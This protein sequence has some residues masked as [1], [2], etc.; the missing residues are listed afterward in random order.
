MCMCI[1]LI[2]KTIQF[3]YAGSSGS[4]ISNTT[5]CVTYGNNSVIDI[6]LVREGFNTDGGIL[7]CHT[8]DTTCCRRIDNPPN[9]TDRGEWYYP[10]GTVVP[11]P[12]DDTGLYRTREHMVIAL[13]R[14]NGAT[15][16]TGAYRCELPGSGGVN[17]TKYITLS[18]TGGT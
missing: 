8:D 9:G 16:P 1:I 18:N 3:I 11:P 10:N 17:I 6:N 13:H 15:E 5:Y 4:Q 2:A 14:H 7:G 12:S